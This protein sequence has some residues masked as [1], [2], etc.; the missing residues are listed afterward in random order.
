MDWSNDQKRVEADRETL[1]ADE[2]T[3]FFLEPD[4]RP[5]GL[6]SRHIHLEQSASRLSGF[7]DPFRHLG[8]DAS[9]AELL[10]QSSGVIAFVRRE[11]LR[12]FAWS[13]VFAG[14]DGHCIQQRHNLCAFVPIGRHNAGG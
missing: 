4:K 11:D 12:T 7:P 3:V 5:L 2:A 13:T 1:P 10:A 14:V 6:E 9:G 8:T